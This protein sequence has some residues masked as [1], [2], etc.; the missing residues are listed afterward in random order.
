MRL[1][2]LVVLGIMLGQGPDRAVGDEK[3]ARHVDKPGGFSVVPPKAW[4]IFYFDEKFEKSMTEARKKATKTGNDAMKLAEE[5]LTQ[6]IKQLKGPPAPLPGSPQEIQLKTM[7]K[8]L[9]SL[10]KARADRDKMA[11]DA[12]KIGRE[13]EKK[14]QDVAPIKDDFKAFQFMGSGANGPAP[15]IQ[16]NVEH[17]S[18]FTTTINDVAVKSTLANVVAQYKKP[19]I[20]LTQKE[21]ETFKVVAEKKLKTDAGA[22][23]LVLVTEFDQKGLRYRQT[24]YFFDLSEE[25]KLVATCNA[26]WIDHLDAVFEASVKTLRLEKP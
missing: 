12:E 2:L 1:T 10:A 19:P 21:A 24:Y 9:E 11:R 6:Q 14:E 23:C 5:R 18:R 22:E 17:L 26:P 7:E 4:T 15:W 25:R 16:F 8:V 13:A 3:P 20:S